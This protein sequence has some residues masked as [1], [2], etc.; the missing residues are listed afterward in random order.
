MQRNDMEFAR[1]LRETFRLEAEEHM[2]VL[3]AIPLRLEKCNTAPQVLAV[4]EEAFREVHSLKGAART[5]NLSSVERVCHALENVFS[6]LKR[7]STSISEP[8]LR[9]IE[10]AIATLEK[11]LPAALADT[12][13]V[14][15]IDPAIAQ[16]L[17]ALENKRVSPQFEGIQPQAETADVRPVPETASTTAETMRIPVAQ[18][19]TLMLQVEELRAP[20]VTARQRAAEL[21]ELTAV[22]QEWKRLRARVTPEL[23]QLRRVS[24]GQGMAFDFKTKLAVNRTF[25]FLERTDASIAE[26]QDRSLEAIHAADADQRLLAGMVDSLLDDVKRTLM[27]PLSSF[28][29]SYPRLLK[30]MAREQGKQIDVEISGV[31]LRVDRR[32]LQELKAPLI[33]LL[34]NVIDHGIEAAEERVRR[35]KP[36]A[37][38]LRIKTAALEGDKFQLQI[39]DDGAGIDAARVREAALNAGIIAPEQA[40]QMD[41]QLS[42]MLIFE[43][44]VSTSSV[45]SDLSGR[46]LGLA[47]VQDKIQRLG[48][49]IAI[50]TKPGENTRLT[51]EL[52]LTLTAF[53]GIVVR[54]GEATFVVPVNGIERVLRVRGE[55]IRTIENRETVMVEEQPVS[56]VRLSAVLGMKTSLQATDDKDWVYLLVLSTSGRRIAY[57][58]DEIVAEQEVVVKNLG[59]FLEGVPAFSGA[60]VLSH[61]RVVPILHVPDLVKVASE[62]SSQASERREGAPAQ[63]RQGGSVLVVEDSITA[64]VLLKNILETA[65]YRVKT[66]VDGSEAFALLKTEPFDLVVSDVEMPRMDG[67]ELTSKI[68]ADKELAEMPVVLVTGLESREDRERGVDVGANAYVVKSSFDQSNLLEVVARLI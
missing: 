39:E 49:N 65:G 35:G 10:V 17:S 52:P 41:E 20:K 37:G 30:E 15:E 38:R 54:V 32:I 59:S 56:F 4:V 16:L 48:G 57:A 29:E 31:E 67:F 1:R 63:Q 11:L 18:L 2:Q 66:A 60:T 7:R 13:P 43:S 22:I 23:R 40:E 28:F 8:L 68:R 3:A 64:R 42:L 33:H 12:T 21:R 6:A 47:I 46:G 58:V 51:I 24:S 27:L 19:S 61:G 14:P 44:G 25:E 53:K 26:L 9:A 36:P 62:H 45:V 5:V 55:S 34:R 50:S